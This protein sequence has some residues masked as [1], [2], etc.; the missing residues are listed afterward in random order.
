MKF[1]WI[2]IMLVVLVIAFITPAVM[3]GD[4]GP[5]NT[6]VQGTN[7]QPPQSSRSTRQTVLKWQDAQGR[8]HFGDEAPEGANVHEVKV[9][10]AANILA[11][12]KVAAKESENKPSAPAM[13]DMGG[14]PIATPAKAME[15]IEQANQVKA[16]MEK[17]NEALELR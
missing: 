11:P 9:D 1:K 13:P 3:T 14:L 8:W 15:A 16:M 5:L 17:R 6:M 12:V 4:F 7:Y 10:T 2:F